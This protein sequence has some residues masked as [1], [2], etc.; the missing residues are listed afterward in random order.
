MELWMLLSNGAKE[1]SQTL[2]RSFGGRFAE[3]KVNSMYLDRF[4]K[5]RRIEARISVGERDEFDGNTL[6]MLPRNSKVVDTFRHPAA[7]LQ[8]ALVESADK[9]QGGYCHDPLVRVASRIERHNPAESVLCL[10]REVS[11]CG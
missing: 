1:A 6:A 3:L 2:L 4:L 5:F 7:G 9:D 11:F 10:R 8:T